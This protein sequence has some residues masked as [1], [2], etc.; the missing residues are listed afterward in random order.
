[1][2]TKLCGNGKKNINGAKIGYMHYAKYD[3]FLLFF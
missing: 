3:L 1:M 2:F